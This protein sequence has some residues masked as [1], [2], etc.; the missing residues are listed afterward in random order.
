MDLYLRWKWRCY[1]LTLKSVAGALFLACVGDL[2]VVAVVFL[3]EQLS[4]RERM[5]RVSLVVMVVVGA[6]FV[7]IVG[8]IRVYC[9]S[10]CS[11]VWL[12]LS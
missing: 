3:E 8:L 12:S 10:D 4:I 2:F 1:S 5:S 7:V 9:L 11:L 6:A